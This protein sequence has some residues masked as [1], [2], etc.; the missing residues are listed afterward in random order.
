AGIA[1]MN[2]AIEVL[3]LNTPPVLRYFTWLPGAMGCLIGQ[4]DLGIS[5]AKGEFPVTMLRG[6][7][8]GS[9]LQL[10][11]L[12]SVLAIIL[13]VAVGM[14]TA[15]RQYSGYDYTVTFFTFVIYSLP[16][17]WVAVLLK[18]Y[19]AVELNKFI[20]NPDIPIWLIV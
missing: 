12:A 5:L 15:L 19:G 18:Q 10:I 11:T 3:N 6:Q 1:K 13:C 20:E 2:H 8:L 7:A 9:T 4:C 14:A 17:F 16:V